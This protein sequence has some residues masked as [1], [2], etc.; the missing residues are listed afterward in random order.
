[1]KIVVTGGCGFIGSSFVNYLRKRKGIKAEDI[2]VVD[3]LTYA[4]NRDLI[5]PSIPLLVK[6]ICN[7]TS[8]DLGDFDYIIN[9]AA[10][11]HVDNSIKDGLPFV[12]TNVEGTFNLLEIARKNPKLKKFIQIST[13]EVYGDM[14]SA[15][16]P[17]ATEIS[18]LYPSSYYSATKAAADHLVLAAKR[19]YGLPV[20]ITRTCNNFGSHQHKEKFLPTIYNSIM[21]GRPIPLYGDGQHKREWIWVEDNVR[22]IETL[23]FKEVGIWNVGSGD[24]WTNKSIIERIGGILGKKVD[25]QY[26]D[27]RLGHDRRYTINT[28]KL[29]MKMK[30][31]KVTTK[32]LDKFLQET[33]G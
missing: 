29:E 15:R 10:E 5:E 25:F 13:D 32:S 2:F 16:L 17:S 23:M 24:V 8:D 19:T 21:E 7:V 4:S 28:N 30:T 14:D 1:M 12:K 26:V 33:F 3:K 22:L 6:D 27:D 31:Y 20:L 11:S 18:R 9:F